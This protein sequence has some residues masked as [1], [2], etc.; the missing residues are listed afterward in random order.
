MFHLFLFLDR[1]ILDRSMDMWLYHSGFP[2]LVKLYIPMP[3]IYCPP[4][5]PG[6]NRISNFMSESAS[7][8][9]ES[10]SPLGN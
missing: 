9:D 1:N 8:M 7:D 4:L 10:N 6:S 3:D 5:C 2:K